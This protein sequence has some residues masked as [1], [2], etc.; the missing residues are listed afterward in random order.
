V[1]LHAGFE[2]DRQRFVNRGGANW[3][4]SASLR[5]NLFN[6]YQ[7]RARID[8][9]G[10]GLKRAQAL[11]Q[12]AGAQVRMQV[13]RAYADFQS[14]AQRI[15]VA[16]AAVAMAEESLR[17]TRNRYENG[18]GNVTDLLRTETALLDARTRQ[19]A[20][21]YDQRLSAVSLSLASGTLTKDSPVLN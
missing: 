3:L 10:F 14:A 6:G 1:V 11:E 5:W 9:A 8:E 2:A 7:D 18:L 13:R 21:V 15:E 17:I 12:Q 16:Q 19:L 4:A 20:A